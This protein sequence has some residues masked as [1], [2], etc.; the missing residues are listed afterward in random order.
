[1]WKWI[2]EID[3]FSKY[4]NDHND[5][6]FV[7]IQQNK[8]IFNKKIIIIKHCK[9]TIH[10]PEL[11]FTYANELSIAIRNVLNRHITYNTMFLVSIL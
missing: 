6:Q 3:S 4:F 1:M 10:K 11:R 2:T 8:T 5:I 7:F 9:I